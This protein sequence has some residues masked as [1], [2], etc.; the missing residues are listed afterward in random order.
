MSSY[1]FAYILGLLADGLWI[2]DG[3][4]RDGAEQLLLILPIKRGL[5]HQH[6]VQQNTIG[7]PIDACT[8]A[9]KTEKNIKS[10]KLGL[11]KFEQEE[12]GGLF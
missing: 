9:L 11:E 2:A 8:I 10:Q 5:T 6:F 1:P 12:E 4:V 3:V 7:P